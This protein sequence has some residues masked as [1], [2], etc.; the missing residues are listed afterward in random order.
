MTEPAT[1]IPAKQKDLGRIAVVAVHGV[2]DHIPGSSARK[3]SDL[4]A[5]L[6]FSNSRYTSFVEESIAIA[7]QPV[8]VRPLPS[9]LNVGMA[10]P[11][12]ALAKATQKPT[13][14][15]GHTFMRAQLEDYRVSDTERTYRS[16]RLRGVRQSNP[17]GPETTV[18]V[19]ELYWKDL[20]SLGSGVAT[21]FGELYQILFHFASLGCQA[22]RGTWIE[23]P[24]IRSWSAFA[25]VQKWTSLWLA[26]LI[27]LINLFMLGV[28]VDL[29]ASSIFAR[30][31]P[32][33][34]LIILYCLVWITILGLVGFG[35]LWI[36]R[37]P[38]FRLWVTPVVI[39]IAALLVGVFLSAGLWK[40]P[41]LSEVAEA[42]LTWQNRV[43]SL[44]ALLVPI[45]LI[46]KITLAYDKQR[47]GVATIALFSGVL[48]VVLI[49]LRIT[50]PPSDYATSN[51]AKYLVLASQVYIIEV[52]RSLLDIIWLLFFGLLLLSH[53][54]GSIAVRQIPNE[55]GK[56]ERAALSRWTARLTIS[57]SGL[58]VS[59]LTVVLWIVVTRALSLLLPND[60]T[61]D[62]VSKDTMRLIVV[63]PN[64][65]FLY[66]AL[67][68]MI[69]LAMILDAWSLAPSGWAELFP[70]QNAYDTVTASSESQALGNWMTNGYSL[71][72]WSGRV[73]Y[74]TMLLVYPLGLT[75]LVR[76]TP[77]KGPIA[78]LMAYI[79]ASGSDGT[80]ENKADGFLGLLTLAFA[81]TATSFMALR[82]SLT[83]IALGFRPVVSMVLDVDNYFREHPLD[84][85]PRARIAARY[86]SLLRYL[87]AWREPQTDKRYK[88]IVIVAHSQ[89]TAITADLLRFIRTECSASGNQAFQSYDDGLTPL[90][91]D[92]PIYL[93]TMG[94]PLHQVYGRLFPDL[95]KWTRTEHASQ[96]PVGASISSNARPATQTIGVAGWTNAFRSGD[97]IGRQLWGNDNSASIWNIPSLER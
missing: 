43:F 18:D 82:G 81:G 60:F 27:P 3:V 14:D 72:R 93:F 75:L 15:Q 22:V 92:L 6:E 50:F 90:D 84:S 76:S 25:T 34:Q 97:Y 70:R 28:A 87:C 59:L 16:I 62:S 53:L 73:L 65:N 5:N 44:F 94:S 37:R 54:A 61:Y 55:Q 30:L 56:P 20:S 63:G 2:G 12:E 32:S 46:A 19:F 74:C 29:M 64:D 10:G 69:V 49:A 42:S 79:G 38:G 39:V 58:A 11:F 7:V 40:I 45:G 67:F 71:M 85:N 31:E 21:L 4:L 9:D 77:V 17:S 41:S 91:K 1:A 13:D 36:R 57:L 68:G 80:V 48:L 23:N 52:L 78:S 51:D 35:I 33:K 83:K 89:G 24:G 95:Y 66:A 26:V 96:P 8:K 47:P 86:V 88:A